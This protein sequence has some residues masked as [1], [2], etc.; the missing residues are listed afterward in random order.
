MKALK[1]E[2]A[3]QLLTRFLIFFVLAITGCDNSTEVKSNIV[4]A[5][6]FSE[7]QLNKIQN[8]SL[9]LTEV[10]QLIRNLKLDRLEDNG[11]SD[12]KIGPFVVHLDPDGFNTGTEVNNIPAGMYKR[13]KFEMHK[14]E[15]NETPPD[16]EFKDGNSGS[17]R[18][19]LIVKGSYNNEPFVYKSQRTIYQEIEFAPPLTINDSKAFN[20]K[21]KVNPYSWFFENGDY[22]NPID[23]ANRSEIEMKI[24]HSFKDAYKDSNKDGIPD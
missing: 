9:L 17:E 14:L 21:I 13:V 10:K 1:K 2:E 23:E 11:S 22:I 20:F 4:S 8:N 19:S 18:Y 15:D 3:M 16:S 7:S 6:F 5:S 24:E 12:V